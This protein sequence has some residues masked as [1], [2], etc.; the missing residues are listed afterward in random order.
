MISLT[1]INGE[2]FILNDD[3]IETIS[4]TH[5][6]VITLTKG[7]KFIVTESPD[8]IVKK[9]IEFRRSVFLNIRIENSDK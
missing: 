4:S 7:N 5:D 3:L 2:I 8:E 9:V 6:T 1:R